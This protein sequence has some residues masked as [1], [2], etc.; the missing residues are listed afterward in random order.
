MLTLRWYK[1]KFIWETVDIPPAHTEL[2]CLPPPPHCQ[3]QSL[4]REGPNLWYSDME[5]V[6][7]ISKAGVS[8][9]WT[10]FYN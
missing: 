4:S 2:A 8:S 7:K 3:M 9:P 10:F 5:E 1:H 6:P